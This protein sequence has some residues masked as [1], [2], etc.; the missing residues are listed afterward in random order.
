MAEFE[1]MVKS[2][3]KQ[4]EFKEKTQESNLEELEMI[5]WVNKPRLQWEISVNW[6]SSQILNL[7][8]QIDSLDNRVT[9]LENA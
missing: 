3:N 8:N 4:K 5:P 9:A 6:E 2:M 1:S 7:Q